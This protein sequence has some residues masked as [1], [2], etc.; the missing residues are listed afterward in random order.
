[1]LL[2]CP[3][4]ALAMPLFRQPPAAAVT[5]PT[6]AAPRAHFWHGVLALTLAAVMY[7]LAVDG[8]LPLHY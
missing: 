2:I 4:L 5:A 7:V 8:N 6:P 1:M 3:Q